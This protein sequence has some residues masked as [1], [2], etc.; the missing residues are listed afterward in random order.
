MLS[1]CAGLLLP[2][3]LRFHRATE[4]NKLEARLRKRSTETKGSIEKRLGRAKCELKQAETPGLYDMLL[5]NENV[6]ASY[7]N[8][9][10][11]TMNES[12]SMNEYCMRL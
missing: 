9:E 4:F 3:L 7:G 12:K 2:R 10:E 6:A 8:F 1:K 5:V 11:L